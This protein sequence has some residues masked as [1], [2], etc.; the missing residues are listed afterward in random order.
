MILLLEPG[1]LQ[2][3]TIRPKTE[4]ES[5]SPWGGGLGF[6][7]EIAREAAYFSVSGRKEKGSHRAR[8]YIFG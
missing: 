2:S 3:I 7:V 8:A 1:G 5:K 6:F 4:Q